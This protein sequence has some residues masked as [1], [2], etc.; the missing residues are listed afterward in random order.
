[1]TD[2]LSQIYYNRGLQLSRAAF[3]HEA[4]ASLIRAISY[5]PNNISA[6]NLDGLCYYRMGKFKTA[7]YCWAHSVNRS[8]EGNRALAYLVDLKMALQETGPAFN[9]L[10]KLCADKK[11]G[12][13]AAVLKK[14]I[15]PFFDAAEDLLTMLGILKLLEGKPGP[16]VECFKK[17]VAVNKRSPAAWR[18]LAVAKQKPGY[19]FFRIKARLINFI[20]GWGSR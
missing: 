13:A 15:I 16:A 14:E 7:G 8:R 11:Y 20:K 10:N 6:W 1:M 5:D 9:R 2:K 3:L 18:Y 17:A 4:A 12:H 19:R